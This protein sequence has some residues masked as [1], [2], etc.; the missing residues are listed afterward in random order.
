MMKN[1][2]SNYFSKYVN[3]NSIFTSRNNYSSVVK[4]FWNNFKKKFIYQEVTDDALRPEM[5]D[6]FN[7]I[8]RNSYDNF[9]KNEK[10]LKSKADFQINNPELTAMNEFICKNK[11]FI[12]TRFSDLLAKTN[13]NDNNIIQKKFPTGTC[14]PFGVKL[15]MT[16]RGKVLPC[17]KI[18]FKNY[19]FQVDKNPININ[20]DKIT[21][22]YN[23]YFNKIKDLCVRCSRSFD[24][25][26]CIFTIDYNNNK[27]DCDRFISIEEHSKSLSVYFDILE[28]RPFLYNKVFKEVV[29][30]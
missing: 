24:C 25:S 22:M 28:N 18:D 5:R 21:K 13:N 10:Y 9:K 4:F 15:F 7:K 16:S 8:F 30:A 29:I 19:L 6:E 23:E 1:K 20:Y 12:V 27:F 3:F 17:E 14:T 2:Y 26:K 11:E